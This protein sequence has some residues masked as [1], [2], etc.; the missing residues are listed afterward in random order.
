MEPGVDP[1]LVALFGSETRVRTL[2]VLAGAHRPVTAY[3]IGKVGAIPIHK[4]YEEVRRLGKVGLVAQR[5][6]G[7][8][9]LDEEV[10][11]LLR[12]RVRIAWSEDWFA[13][14]NRRAEEERDLLERLRRIPHARPPKGWK[15]RDPKRF[16]RSPT[17]DRILHEM[18][19]RESV[20]A[21]QG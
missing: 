15:P 9:L 5:A 7:W 11:A 16:R 1:R 2:A 8:V 20:H 12:R 18:G 4:A 6:G 17:K 14:R 3:R 21:D 19:L 13:E 10:R